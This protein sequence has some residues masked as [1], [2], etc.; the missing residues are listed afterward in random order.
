[1]DLFTSRLTQNAVQHLQV[2]KENCWAKYCTDWLRSKY[3]WRHSNDVIVMKMP[4]YRCICPQL[5]S[6]QNI[7]FQIF[8]FW[9]LTEWCFVTYSW[10]D[11]RIIIVITWMIATLLHVYCNLQLTL[12]EFV[13]WMHP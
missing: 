1:L 13:V 3:K 12:A 11:P 8:I 4:V 5:N 6:L 9:K 7:Y 2:A 10:N